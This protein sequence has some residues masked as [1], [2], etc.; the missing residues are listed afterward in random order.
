LPDDTQTPAPAPTSRRQRLTIRLGIGFAAAL[1]LF[2]LVV[3]VLPSPLAR[4]V[5]DSQLENLGI[6]HS[7][8]DTVE[9]D[10]W[11]SHVRAGPMTFHSNEAQQGQIGETGFDYSFGAF[12]KGRAFVQTFYL[13]GVD[14]YIARLEDGAIEINGIN[15]QEIGA[16]EDGTVAAA[17]QAAENEEEKSG[18]DVGVERFEFA[19]SQM[20]FEDVSGGTLTIEVERLT[21]DR[22]LTW[23][24]EEPTTFALQGRL[25]EMDLAFDG[26]VVPLGDP[27]RFT[28]NSRVTGITLDRI[29]RFIGPTGLTRQDGS[30]NTEVHYAYAIH[31]D[32]RIEGT[33]DGTYSFRDFA[34]ATPEGATAALGKALLKVD[35][36]Q[37][38]L[39][40]GSASATGQLRLQASPLS[41]ATVEGDGVEI[42]ELDLAFADL[43]FRK[44]AEPR[45]RMVESAGPA[46]G[47]DALA[48]RAPSIVELMIGWAREL[49]REAL[50]HQLTVHGSP[51]LNLKSGLVRVAARGDLPGQELRFDDLSVSLG[52]VASQA[53]D[54]GWSAAGGLE[55]VATA[56]RLATDGG[57]AEA[58]LAILR[59]NAGAIDLRATTEETRLAFDLKVLLEQLAAGDGQGSTL[60]LSAFS[61]ASDGFTIRQTADSEEA[62]GPLALSLENLQASLP[63]D[64]GTMSLRGDGLDLDLAALTLI[65]KGAE[66]GTLSGSLEAR[67]ISLERGGTSPLSF[68]LAST[69]SDLQDLRIAPLGPQAEIQGGLTTNLSGITLR[70]STGTETFSLALDSLENSIEG[71]RASGFDGNEITVS[72]AN[73]TSLSGLTAS[74]PLGNGETAE[75]GIAALEA[76]LSELAFAGN[77]LRAKGALE[78]TGI[79]ATTGGD[80]AQSLDL[81]SLSISGFSGDSDVGVEAES[82]ALGELIAKLALPLPGTSRESDSEANTQGGADEPPATETA[83][84]DTVDAA[85]SF[86]Q[87]IKVG[88]FTLAPGSRI[89]ISD[90]SVEPPL[91]ASIA[92]D[93]LNVGPLD[94]GA[95]ETRTDL[96]LALTANESSKLSLQGWASP[97]EPKPDFEVTSRVEAFPL[98]QFSAYAA[99]AVGVNIESGALTADVAANASDANLLGNIDLKVD[100]LFVTP[101]SEEEA[102]KIE[103]DIGLPVGFAVSILKDSEGVIAFGMPLSGTVDSPQV[104]YSEAIDKAISGAM[105]SVFPTNWFGPDG[106]TFE[107]QPAPFEPGTTKLTADGQ[108]VADQMGELFAGK[109]GI[110]IR[111]CGRAGRDDLVALRGD[112]PAPPEK[113]AA[114]DP[115]PVTPASASDEV[116]PASAP[117]AA[118]ATTGGGTDAAAAPQEIAKP[119]EQ[120]IEKLLALASDRGVAI[121]QY[122]EATYGIDPAR[123]P[124]CRTAYSIEDGKSPRAEF[125]F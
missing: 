123:V 104:D 114:A 100:D 2:V 26:T 98:H 13:H 66:A 6:Q 106:N 122:L 83:A 68:A 77:A 31:S 44:G 57:G 112:F 94:T 11:N 37:E 51:T 97:F 39:P 70:S 113:L 40:D 90:G 71:L 125:Q 74:L 108:A 54:S 23:T 96:V 42:A 17:E 73:R 99:K 111:T 25:N 121:R 89:E 92:I 65:G 62:T 64:D 49:G 76:P 56:L 67:G 58:N 35:L 55:T 46:D 8:I 63:G 47:A 109:P 22:L 33:V 95:P 5:I 91:Q 1:T 14:L 45:K 69:R 29:A 20:V 87:R 103:A 32:G 102:E 4:Y 117:A 12:F 118:P 7:G 60:G 124:E 16:P 107:M 105:A 88:R 61:L 53:F 85:P 79:S 115:A 27:L 52:E 28:F 15:L 43:D 72:L 101:L 82:V 41:I 80:A 110:S 3:F 59:A 38:L 75:A 120:E 36:E 84:G 18:F 24:P 81:A 50:G 30:L 48:R 19:D 78:V 86:D 34:I 9:I 93:E 21:L 10:L 119:S 116:T